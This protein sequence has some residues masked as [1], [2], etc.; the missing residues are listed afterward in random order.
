MGSPPAATVVATEAD[1][2]GAY[3]RLAAAV[4]PIVDRD[5]CVLI[6]IMMGGLLPLARLASMLRGDFSLDYCQVSRYRG[7]T[8]GGE[9][10]WL[11]PPTLPLEGR[12]VL[13]IDDIFDEGL[14]L[15]YVVRA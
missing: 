9:L 4:P 10:E 3:A 7:T 11:Q 13:L 8:R 14:T 1:V 6:G 5:D 2:A 12:T 15:D